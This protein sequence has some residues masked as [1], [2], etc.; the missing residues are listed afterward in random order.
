[1]AHFS[2][3]T[4]SDLTVSQLYALLALRSDVFVVEQHCPY[5]DIDG[6]D[7][8][9]LHLLG[10]EDEELVAYIRLFPPTEIENYVEFGRVVTAKSARDK[11]H[12]KRLLKEL[13]NYCQTHFPDITIQC[14][15]Q[16]YLKKF[17][18]SFGFET[19]GEIYEE[20]GIP[21]IAMKKVFD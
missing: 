19:Y 12:G 17:Y 9:A 11:G 21:H 16:H 13:L 6:K 8:Y 4:F 20:D 7:M 2:W 1:M 3:H 15:A 14:S 5:L 18:E 10:M